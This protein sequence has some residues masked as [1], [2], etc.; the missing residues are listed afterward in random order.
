MAEKYTVP[1]AYLCSRG[2]RPLA[3]AQPLHAELAPASA[4]QVHRRTHQREVRERLREVPQQLP[5]TH[6]DLLGEQP[7]WRAEVEQPLEAPLRLLQVSGVG[8]RVHQPERGHE[9]CTLI[10]SEPVLALV[11]EVALDEH[12]L[13]EVL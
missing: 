13:A 7:E 5:G 9:E 3:L 6:V 1:A 8:E 10:T 11:Q 4:L 12:T 2:L